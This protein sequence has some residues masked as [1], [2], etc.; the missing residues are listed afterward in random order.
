MTARW[1]YLVIWFVFSFWGFYYA[2]KGLQAA[3]DDRN[4]IKETKVNSAREMVSKMLLRAS[5]FR[6][7]ICSTALLV[8]FAALFH[9]GIARFII[10]WGLILILVFQVQIVRLDLKDREKLKGESK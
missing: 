9:G 2:L 10:T 4:F 6:M 3:I 5:W 8:G 1:I 7:F